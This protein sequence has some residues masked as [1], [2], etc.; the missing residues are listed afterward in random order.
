MYI[1]PP[2]KATA[3]ARVRRSRLVRARTVNKSKRGARIASR[4]PNPIIGTPSVQR[5]PRTPRTPLVVRNSS[6]TPTTSTHT[7][8]ANIVE[9]P[10]EM[11]NAYVISIRSERYSAIQKR[12]GPWAKHLKLW[13]GTDGRRLNKNQWYREKKFMRRFGGS[14]TRG[15]LG[16]Y[17]SHARLWKMLAQSNQEMALILEDDAA[18]FYNASVANR[19]RSA[20]ENLKKNNVQWDL[21]YLGHY[22]RNTNLRRFSRSSKSSATNHVCPGVTVCPSWQGLFAYVLTKQG[23][24]KLLRGLW[25]AQRPVDTYVQQHINSGLRAIKLEPRLCYVVPVRSDTATI[26]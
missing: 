18:I 26:I 8:S 22:G 25:P 1:I 10:S 24:Q 7:T 2:K 17:D 3:S 13:R 16:C 19:L 11:H 15:E 5:I 14:M 12:F 23:A 21:F 9:L 4:T 6:S 20:F